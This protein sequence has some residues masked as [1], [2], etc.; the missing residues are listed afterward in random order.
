MLRTMVLQ[1]NPP[2]DIDGPIPSRLFASIA[3]LP[4]LMIQRQNL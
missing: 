1:I 4:H 3:Y 2:L